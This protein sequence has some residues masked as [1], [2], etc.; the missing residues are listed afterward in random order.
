M[1]CI[2]TI[3]LCMILFGYLTA[4][5]LGA[6]CD[7]NADGSVN[8][9]DLQVLINAILEGLTAGSYDVNQDGAVNA[10]DLQTLANVVL[11]TRTCPG[12]ASGKPPQLAGCQIFPAD[13]PWNRDISSD[14][15][16]PNSN[17]YIAHMN[18]NTK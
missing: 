1:R 6:A 11:G 18:G 15:V 16:D 17:N 5:S 9:L 4:G 12:S 7:V 8:A 3:L 10:L 14:P 13:N 2:S